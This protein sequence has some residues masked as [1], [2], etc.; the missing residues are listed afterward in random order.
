MAADDEVLLQV[1]E[2][3]QRKFDQLA[4]IGCLL[5]SPFIVDLC[6]KVCDERVPLGT[7]HLSVSWIVEGIKNITP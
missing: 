5:S 1:D 2:T 6:S 3:L 7:V 4:G